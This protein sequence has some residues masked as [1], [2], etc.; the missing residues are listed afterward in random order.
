MLGTS[1][2]VNDLK[3]QYDDQWAKGSTWSIK[4]TP[5][6]T[7]KS[8]YIYYELEN[9]YSNHRNFVKSR[10][11]SQLRGNTGISLS[12]CSPITSNSDISS[13]LYNLNNYKLASGDDANPWGLIAKYIFND[14]FSLY[15]STSNIS[16]DETDISQKVD[17]DYK[18]IRPNDYKN[19]QW[20]DN[21]DQHLMVW[22][23]PD[24]FPDFKKLYGKISTD[25]DAGTQY[26]IMVKNNYDIQNA[27]IKKY[28]FISETNN[29]GGDNIVFG[30]LYISAS[31]VLF[32][33]S[34]L[35]V[36]LEIR[37]RIKN[38]NINRV[39]NKG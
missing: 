20:H 14:T 28:I 29:F 38:K 15:N 23:E 34:I 21:E 24:L 5:D 37:Q 1:L 2:N 39:G 9:F 10:S 11:Y 8:P 18:F 19:I 27:S 36:S 12:T 6:V 33:L 22:F 26:T 35:M 3:I 32:I 13:T 31:G 30:V 17:K 7:L 4:F 25:L 16:I